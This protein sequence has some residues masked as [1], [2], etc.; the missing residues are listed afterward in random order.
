MIPEIPYVGGRNNF[1]SDM[2]V[3]AAVILALYRT[4]KK[5]AVSLEEF[6]KVLEEITINYINDSTP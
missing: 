1:F 2:P 3:K 4:L 5:E 6:G